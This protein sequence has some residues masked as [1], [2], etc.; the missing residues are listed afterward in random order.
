MGIEWVSVRV[1]GRGG[2]YGEDEDE[3]GWVGGWNCGRN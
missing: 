3:G 2:W 1:N